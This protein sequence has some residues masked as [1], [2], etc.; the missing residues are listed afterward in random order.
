MKI[1]KM[2]G[3][4]GGANLGRIFKEGWH[5]MGLGPARKI[6]ELVFTFIDQSVVLKT[7]EEWIREAIADPL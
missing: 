1:S 2:A 7:L 5:Q 6:L 3:C 4:S